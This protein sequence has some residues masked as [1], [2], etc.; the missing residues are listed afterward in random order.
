[1]AVVPG[2]CTSK[3]QPLDVSINKPFKSELRKS[4]TGYIKDASKVGPDTG[5]C[6]KSASK[7]TVVNWIESA[8]NS[9]TERPD[10]VRKSFKACGISNNLKGSE[11][12][13]ILIDPPVPDSLIA[14]MKNMSLRWFEPSDLPQYLEE[15]NAE[16]E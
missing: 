6:V 14:T 11:D 15:L 2:G 13:E 1:M 4:W 5:E 9:L 7:E 16:S 3:L 8:V 10:M 12:S